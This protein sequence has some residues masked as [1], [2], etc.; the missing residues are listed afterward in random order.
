MNRLLR[1]ARFPGTGSTLNRAG[2]CGCPFVRNSTIR[3]CTPRGRRPLQF[4]PLTAAARVWAIATVLD[5]T[6]KKGL[7]KRGVAD[8]PSYW[9]TQLRGR[10][11]PSAA[12]AGLRSTRASKLGNRGIASL[13]F[14]ICGN[15]PARVDR[16]S[17]HGRRST[18]ETANLMSGPCGPASMHGLAGAGSRPR[19]SLRK[20]R[21]RRRCGAACRGAVVRSAGHGTF[22]QSGER[23]DGY[24]LRFV[25]TRHDPDGTDRRIRFQGE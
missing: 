14:V 16:K 15:V 13:R 24:R 12:G 8:V 18:S 11:I 9:S 17:F 10:L 7:R 25:G 21:E 23:P 1:C 20:P 19:A 4:R 3:A 5:G 6:V 22:Q 2:P